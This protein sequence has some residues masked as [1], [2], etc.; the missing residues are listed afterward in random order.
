MSLTTDPKDPELGRGVDAGPVPQNKKYLV[1][2]EEE[3]SKGFI[4]PVRL[5]YTHVGIKGPQFQLRDLTEEEKRD[6]GTDWV[7]FETYPPRHKGSATGRFWTQ[8]DLDKVGKG[9][10]V[11]TRMG[12]AIAETYARNPGFYGATYCC[13]CHRHLPVG[14]DGEFI[15]DDGSEERVGT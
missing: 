11:S 4:R 6:Y 12:Q 3:L 15:W 10:G 5:S 2:S 9:C 14:E 13:T 1:L 8:A 7:K